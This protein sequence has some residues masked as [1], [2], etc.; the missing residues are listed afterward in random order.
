[1]GDG[2]EGKKDCSGSYPRKILSILFI[3]LMLEN[4]IGE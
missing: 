1:M 3:L 4:Y 2:V